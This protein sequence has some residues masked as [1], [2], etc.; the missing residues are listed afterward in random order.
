MPE[1][2]SNKAKLGFLVYAGMVDR[3]RRVSRDVTIGRAYK[4]KPM[5]AWFAL[6]RKP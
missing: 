1:I 3:L 6:V 5:N 2:I 4:N